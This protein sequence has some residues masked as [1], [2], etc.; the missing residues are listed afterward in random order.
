MC[1]GP[2]GGMKGGRDGDMVVTSIIHNGIAR[3]T[4]CEG[5]GESYIP[6]GITRLS[7]HHANEPDPSS[8]V[9]FHSSSQGYK[10]IERIKILN[11]RTDF[12]E[13]VFPHKQRA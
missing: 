2:G 11:D 6:I 1:K 3:E 8:V 7:K 13:A 5:I 9:C 10:C 12:K 4:G